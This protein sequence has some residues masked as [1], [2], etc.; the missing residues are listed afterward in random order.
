MCFYLL[1]CRFRFWLFGPYGVADLLRKAPYPFIQP[2]LREYGATIGDNCSIDTGL[3]IHRP[4]LK[5]PFKNLMIGDNCYIGHGV[6]ADLSAQIQIEN[7]VAVGARCQFWTHVGD[8]RENLADRINDYRER[9]LP[10]TVG[11]KAIIYSGV[12]LNPGVRV[13]QYSRIGAG[14]VIVKDVPEHSFSAGI[15]AKKIKDL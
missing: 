14:S 13:G 4:G 11:Q 9:T 3:T 1:R 10:I 8:F 2:I 15:P 12:I 7:N 6:L 5:K